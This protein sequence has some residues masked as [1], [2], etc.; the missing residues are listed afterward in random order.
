MAGGGEVR[1]FWKGRMMTGVT[2]APKPRMTT[3]AFVVAEVATVGAF[4]CGIV[5]IGG[6]FAKIIGELGLTAGVMLVGAS[7]VLAAILIRLS[8]RSTNARILFTVLM[9]I[10]CI[11]WIA[12]LIIRWEWVWLGVTGMIESLAFTSPGFLLVVAAILF[13]LPGNRPFFT[14]AQASV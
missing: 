11:W 3:I 2:Q 8:A 9:S 1:S 12:S 7:M 6:F 13:W 10:F 5:L 4:G 14:P